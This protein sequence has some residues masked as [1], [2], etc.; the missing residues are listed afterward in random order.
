MHPSQQRYCGARPPAE[1]ADK[2][3]LGVRVSGPPS[4]RR[5]RG[6]GDRVYSLLSPFSGGKWGS[7]TFPEIVTG[8][9]GRGTN[10]QAP[11]FTVSP[12]IRNW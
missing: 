4:P 6:T 7:R 11:S 8:E 2:A 5:R 3:G 12:R 10:V 1:T 9:L